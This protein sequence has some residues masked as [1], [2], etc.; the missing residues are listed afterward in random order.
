MEDRRK[1]R[2]GDCAGGLLRTAAT[3][4]AQSWNGYDL[5]ATLRVALGNMIRSPLSPPDCVGLGLPWLPIDNALAASFLIHEGTFPKPKSRT[6]IDVSLGNLYVPHNF[7]WNGH[8]YQQ[9]Q[10]SSDGRRLDFY[11]DF[12]THED[13]QE[14]ID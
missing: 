11:T 9:E 14:R 1:Q 10:G 6:T 2:G 13:C 4:E 7:S 5:P 12:A 8:A 3:T